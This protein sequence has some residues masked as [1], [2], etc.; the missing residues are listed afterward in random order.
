MDP[1]R[2]SRRDEAT[3][4]G[5]IVL[6]ERLRPMASAFEDGERDAWLRRAVEAVR[7]NPDPDRSWPPET[8]GA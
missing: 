7:A 2:G 5:Q 4:R 3:C 6:Q 8:L 1:K